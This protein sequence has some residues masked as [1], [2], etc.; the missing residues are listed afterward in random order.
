VDAVGQERERKKGPAD[1]ADGP[2]RLRELKGRERA[3]RDRQILAL[4]KLVLACDG[5]GLDPAVL[6]GAILEAAQA[7]TARKEAL[8]AAGHAHFP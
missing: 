4:G 8:A 7:D 6:A 3:I 1:A 5:D 2:Q